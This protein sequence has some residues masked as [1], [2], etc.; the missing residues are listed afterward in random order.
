MA[1][2]RFV[3]LLLS[4]MMPLGVALF[5]H[6]NNSNDV[7]VR[8]DGTELVGTPEVGWNNVDY[9]KELNWVPNR[10]ENGVPTEGYCILPIYPSNISAAEYTSE[11]L[12]TANIPGCNVGDYI[13]INGVASKNIPNVVIYGYP[14]NGFFL[15]VPNDSISHSDEYAHVTINVLEGMSI[16]G[17][18]Q[19]VAT[20]FEY[21]GLLG[22][23]GNWQVNPEPEVRIKGEFS[24]I[25]W[26]NVDYSYTMH[27]TWA[28]EL[29]PNGAPMF[30]YCL[31]AFFNEEGKPYSESVIGDVTM[32]GRGVIGMG[33]NADYKIKVNGVNIIDV[34]D[35]MCYIFPAYGLFF[36]IPNASITYTEE[37]Q[38]PVISL[39]E[40]LHFNNVYLPQMSFEFRGEL[41][42]PNCWTYSKDPSE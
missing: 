17:T 21:R 14:Q 9:S 6:A 28:G 36:Y 4:S 31:L 32:T 15:Y 12:L 22:S 18:A 16:D 23:Y 24:K 35:S 30:G 42:Q 34:A 11:N 39:E 19:T 20:R 40:G 1:K 5:C 29:M 13:L 25:D 8:A 27:Q 38:Y 2:N 10:N 33:L 7:L 3:R 26:N 41:G 37:Y